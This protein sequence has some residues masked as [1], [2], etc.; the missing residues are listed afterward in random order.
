VI[1][2]EPHLH[3]V[4]RSQ[5]GGEII[6]PMISTQWF[7]EIKPLAEKALA[8]VKDGQITIIPEHFTKVYYNWMENIQDWCISRQLWWGHRIPVW[9]CSDCNEVT[10]TREDPKACIHCQ[11][12]NIE[13]D[14][15]VLDTWFSSGL[16]PFSTLGWPD[17]TADLKYFYPT[18]MMETGY[19]ILFFWVARMIMMGLEFTGQVPFSEIYLHGLIR[20]GDGKK[21]S[22]SSGNVIDPITVMDELGTDALRFTMLVGSTPGKDMSL[23]VQKVE[24][25]RNFANKLWNGTRFVLHALETTANLPQ[26]Y[27]PS[28]GHPW[29][30][31]DSW[32]WARL[33]NVIRDIDRLFGNHQYGEAGRHVYDFFWGDFADW[34]VEIAKIQLSEGGDRAFV[35]ART[36]VKVLDLSLRML[37]PF[38]PFVTEELWG[39][40]RAAVLDSPLAA[41]AKDWSQAL[42]IARYPEPRTAEKWE[43]PT[44]VQF[45]LVQEIVRN[46][47]NMRAEYNVKPGQ[48]IPAIFV[49]KTKTGILK[50]QAEV[51]AALA[52]LDIAKVTIKTE[53]EEKPKD[54]VAL[55]IGA[56]EV[57]LPLEEMVDRD[58]QRARLEKE[59]S[60]ANSQIQRLDKLLGSSFAQKAPEQVVAAERDKLENFKE[61]A[62]KLEEQIR[63]LG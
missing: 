27:Q 17:Q 39:H 20:A 50:S 23:S 41:E 5:R 32:I 18:A 48:R 46:I 22:K 15:D 47:R 21:M 14:P 2:E 59:L 34:Y 30:I 53:V 61:T 13:Q 55:V 36:L 3:Q 35:T 26:D 49:S 11:S 54:H 29:T 52:K 1:K 62:Q 33:Q 44:I 25:N 51:I 4:P 57:Y 56:V 6:E 45:E 16:W 43:A 58:E 63:N 60:T 8:A 37:H 38:I 9:Y 12:A 19:D 42:I 7:V 28:S 24:A 31:A 40:L 10:V